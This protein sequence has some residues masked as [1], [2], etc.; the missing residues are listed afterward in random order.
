MKNSI[1]LR[2]R[3]CATKKTRS[4]PLKA[5]IWL[6]E[7]LASILSRDEPDVLRIKTKKKAARDKTIPMKKT[8]EFMKKY[9][10]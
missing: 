1:P 6:A 8:N 10:I 4:A 3:D 9:S 2:N 7:Q 5:A